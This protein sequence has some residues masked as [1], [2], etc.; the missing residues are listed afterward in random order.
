MLSKLGSK[1][2]SLTLIGASGSLKCQVPPVSGFPG[3]FSN[4]SMIELEQTF[5]ETSFGEAPKPEKY[6]PKPALLFTPKTPTA[7]GPVD[8]I[9]TFPDKLLIRYD[10]QFEFPA[11][12][13]GVSF[14][15]TSL[16]VTVALISV[17]SIKSLLYIS[18]PIL[19]TLGIRSTLFCQ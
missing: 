10:S 19:F 17:A 18:Q 8:S 16:I 4:R 6:P 1:I 2:P 7:K 14:M 5:K 12:T 9:L 13:N 15:T 3:I 11:T